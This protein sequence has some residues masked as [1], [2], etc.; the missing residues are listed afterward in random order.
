VQLTRFKNNEGFAIGVAFCRPLADGSGCIKFI[1][2]WAKISRGET[3]E[4]NELPFLDRTILKFSPTPI[5]PG[6]ELIG[7]KPLPLIQGRSDNEVERKKKTTAALLKLTAE[8]VEK[9]K[10]K[11]N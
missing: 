11:A 4:P 5:K 6:F 7:L 10:K 3:L 9:L 2:S 8:E 1:N